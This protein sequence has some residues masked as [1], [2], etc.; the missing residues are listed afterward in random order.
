M[1]KRKIGF[2]LLSVLL[3]ILVGAVALAIGGF[4]PIKAYSIMIKGVISKPRYIAWTII[5]ATPIIF[6]GLSVTF[7]F[8]TGLFNIGAEGQYIVGALTAALVGYFVKGLPSVLH[9]AIIILAAATAAGLWGGTCRTVK[10]KIWC[11]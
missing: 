10:S 9:I 2:I 1:N 11:Q 3:G 4:D 5:R 6:T 8:R 7:A